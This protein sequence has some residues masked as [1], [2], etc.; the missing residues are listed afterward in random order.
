[1]MT[2]VMPKPTPSE[3][4]E[5]VGWEEE[6]HTGPPWKHLQALNKRE[7]KGYGWS[8]DEEPDPSRAVYPWHA[9]EDSEILLWRPDCTS[10][11]FRKSDPPRPEPLAAAWD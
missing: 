10:F 9:G 11:L 2:W 4:L 1:M 7:K 6:Q 5:S 3:K 8:T